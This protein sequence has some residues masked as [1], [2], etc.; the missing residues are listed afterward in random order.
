MA[1]LRKASRRLRTLSHRDRFER[2]LEEEMKFHE[3]MQTAKHVQEGMAPAEARALARR[4]LGSADRF[5]DEVRDVRGV[6]WLDDIRRDVTFA[7]RSLRRSPGFTAIAV[8]CLALGIGANAAIFSVINAVLLRPLPYAEPDRLVRAYE[9]SSSFGGHG[10][11]SP[12]NFQDWQQQAPDLAHLTAWVAA[13]VSL[14]GSAQP[15]RIQVVAATSDLFALAGVRPLAGRP[16]GPGSSTKQGE[17][18]VLGE[19]LWRRRF[20]GDPAVVGRTARIDGTS[21]TILAVM[22]AAF[23]FPPSAAA[24]AWALFDPSPAVRKNR[25][26][27]FLGVAGRLRP[28][29]SATQA[30][31][32]LQQV[33]ARLER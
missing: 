4:E 25:G 14:Q 18:L 23:D 31:A 9:T 22:P 17:V 20:G 2:D 26:G 16:F 33:A 10:S 15:E 6:T 5:K 29:V 32:Q 8:L 28:G 13:S 24:D 3:D 30:Q 19:K 21:Y 1:L 12:A 11:V 27:H 7:L